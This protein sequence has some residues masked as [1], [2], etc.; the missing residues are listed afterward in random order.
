MT[1]AETEAILSA[2]RREV[3]DSDAEW[4]DVKDMTLA[5]LCA[6]ARDALAGDLE[7]IRFHGP[8]SKGAAVLES[9]IATYDGLAGALPASPV[10]S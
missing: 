1:P 8:H 5:G 7:A 9:A 6:F 2:V 4:A 10:A 3:S